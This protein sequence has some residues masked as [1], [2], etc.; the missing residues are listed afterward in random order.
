MRTM[1]GFSGVR[2]E[3]TTDQPPGGEIPRRFESPRHV[4]KLSKAFDVRDKILCG[5]V[6]AHVHAAASQWI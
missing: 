2:L 5:A 3:R 6:L 1:Y 4:D